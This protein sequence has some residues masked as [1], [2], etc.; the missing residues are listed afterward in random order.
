MVSNGLRPNA[1]PVSLPR[2]ESAGLG[3]GDGLRIG[4][5]L[6]AALFPFDPFITESV[7]GA[8]LGPSSHYPSLAGPLLGQSAPPDNRATVAVMYFTNSAL[9]RHDEY[10]P[11]SKGITEMLITEL[12]ASPAIQVVERD[13]LQRLLDEQN[14]SQTDKVDKETAVRLGK[15]LGAHHLLMDLRAVNVETSQVEYVETVSGK[16][17]DVLDL[18]ASLG[19]KV[20]SRLRLPPLPARTEETRKT[21]KASQLRAVMLLSRALNE[22]DKGNVTGAI[23]LY[24]Q[25]LQVYPGYDRARVRLA[26]LE[27][28]PAK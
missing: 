14:L 18:I 8:G 25:A 5:A 28:S 1:R 27:T 12:A 9:V 23:A 7:L 10:G 17:E 26:S 2:L 24:R 6:P 13:Q 4:L 20:N 22:E 11:L 15:I 21:S 3:R 16:A 19:A